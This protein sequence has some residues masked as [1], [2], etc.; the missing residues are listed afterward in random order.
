M[1]PAL[2]NASFQAALQM[3]TMRPFRPARLAGVFA[4]VLV[5][6]ITPISAAVS[7]RFQ[8][9]LTLDDEQFLAGTVAHVVDIAKLEAR[10]GRPV[11]WSYALIDLDA[12]G[13][14]EIAARASPDGECS[15]QGCRTVILTRTPR[16]WRS[17]L[18]T[19]APAIAVAQRSN[20]GLRDLLVDGEVLV[21]NGAQYSPAR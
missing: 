3:V 14:P 7:L 2:P 11:F 10:F 16:M 18:V 21:W 5:S 15:L 20:R 8:P 13:V 4:A 19:D 6:L 9:C 12:D 17:L 1:T